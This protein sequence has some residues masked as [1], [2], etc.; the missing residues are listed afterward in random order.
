M[1]RDTGAE[2]LYAVYNVWLLKGSQEC[3]TAAPATPTGK[4]GEKEWLRG[5]CWLSFSDTVQD[6]L[7]HDWDWLPHRCAYGKSPSE[8]IPHG[9]ALP[10]VC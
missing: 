10:T 5:G 1:E 7:P 4:H 9:D 6:P 2:R 3:E 8:V